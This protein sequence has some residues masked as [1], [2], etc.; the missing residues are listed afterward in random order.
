MGEILEQLELNQTFFYQFI[1][2]FV[3][4]VLLSQIYFK[5]FMKLFE[6]RH[7]RTVEDREAAD[8]LT[9]QASVKLQ[10]YQHRLSEARAT[11]HA[12]FERLI[13]EVKQEESAQLAR[14]RDEAKKITQEAAESV[15]GQ[16][17]K[18][19]RDLEV[20]VESLAHSIAEKFLNKKNG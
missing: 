2:F 15:T 19:R 4:F 14:A 6:L 1:T 3:V 20:D 9:Q 5:P 16:K 11:A 10:E 18:L 17:D 12:E 8:K 7:K 13:D